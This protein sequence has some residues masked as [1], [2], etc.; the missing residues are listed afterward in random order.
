MY[1]DFAEVSKIVETDAA[2]KPVFDY[3]LPRYALIAVVPQ[4]FF[5]NVIRQM[6]NLS[7][8]RII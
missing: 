6:T 3:E 4:F 8:F 1:D 5:E 2:S 7:C